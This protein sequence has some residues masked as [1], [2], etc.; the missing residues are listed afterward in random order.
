MN[1]R[2]TISLAVL[3]ALAFAAEP[4]QTEYHLAEVFIPVDDP[5]NSADA[6]RFAE[7]VIS[8]LHAGAAFAVVAAQ[9]S[10]AQSALE[11]GELGW[12]QTNQLDPA[13]A[14]SAPALPAP[15]RLDPSPPPFVQCAAPGVL[16]G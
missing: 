7:T 5:A 8:E 11:G 15:L 2:K 4:G 1:I 3:I 12:V 16:G 10:Q 13:V 6:Q 14:R 9:F